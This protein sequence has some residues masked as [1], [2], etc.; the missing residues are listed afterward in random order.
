MNAPLAVPSYIDSLLKATTFDDIKQNFNIYELSMTNLKLLTSTHHD[1][2]TDKLDISSTDLLSVLVL[3]IYAKLDRFMD[4][5]GQNSNLDELLRHEYNNFEDKH[6][7]T[8]ERVRY[9]LLKCYSNS[10]YYV[11]IEFIKRVYESIKWVNNR[12]TDSF[13]DPVHLITVL[14]AH[15]LFDSFKRA[16]TDY[17]NEFNAEDLAFDDVDMRPR[18]R[19]KDCIIPRGTNVNELLKNFIYDVYDYQFSHQIQDFQAL[20]FRPSEFDKTLDQ[21]LIN[22][23][24]DCNF[25]IR[26]F[27]TNWTH[28]K[29]KQLLELNDY[30]ISGVNRTLKSILKR[31]E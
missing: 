3:A 26:L 16:L 17:L 5:I 1:I 27:P 29:P 4:I 7:D 13:K 31:Y 2:K 18:K 20:E 11:Y 15:E 22:L 24:N 8:P 21:L 6:L 25:Y 9:T 19:I 10:P 14:A 12:R 30:H 28:Y 23:L